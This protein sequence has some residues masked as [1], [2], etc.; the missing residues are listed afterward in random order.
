[1]L[2][3]T[4]IHDDMQKLRSEIPNLIEDGV[5]QLS[6]DIRREIDQTMK[7]SLYI[8][9]Q[10]NERITAMLQGILS[11]MPEYLSPKLTTL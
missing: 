5:S 6:R 7:N 1:M 11:A 10:E 4:E 3:Q 2:A 9:F 8:L